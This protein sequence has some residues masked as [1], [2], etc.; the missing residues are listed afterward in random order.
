MLLR[1]LPWSPQREGGGEA[2]P[3][4][5]VSWEAAGQEGRE[6]FV[7]ESELFVC[8]L[9]CGARR[10]LHCAS[11]AAGEAARQGNKHPFDLKC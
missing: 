7:P 3:L 11:S 1:V 5:T 4:R 8:L 2:G 6:P 10:G 9:S